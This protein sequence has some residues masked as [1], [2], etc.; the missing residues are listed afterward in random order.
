MRMKRIFA[1]LAIALAAAL[2][3]AAAPG[4]G[5]AVAPLL[6][7]GSGNSLSVS[8]LG[9]DVT[10]SFED[11]S[12]L[13][14]L[15]L[16]LSVYLVNPLDPAFQA[17]LPADT[18]LSALPVMLRIEPPA[19]GGLS[20][21]GVASLDVHTHLLPWAP[22]TPLRLFSAPLGGQ[23]RD[24]TATMGPGSYRVRGITGG[25]SEFLIVLDLRSI[26]QVIATK[27]GALESM[28]EAYEGAMPGSI[29]DDL[30][31]RLAAIEA[32]IAGDDLD[33]AIAGIDDFLEEVEDHSGGTGGIPNQWR[34]ARDR[35]NVAGYLRGGA[36]TLRFSVALKDS[37]GL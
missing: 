29:Y 7:L 17:R 8:L 6:G 34:A 32:D 13:N 3:A 5:I 21:R 30:E 4:P 9:T 18:G 24:V 36:E 14:L 33:G 35:Q 20:F 12:G 27:M 37:L 2:P 26:D 31:D 10:L 15:S 1:F 22:A 25:F 23:F 19:W 11:V 28:L 16:G